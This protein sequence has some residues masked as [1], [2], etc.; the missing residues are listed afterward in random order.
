MKYALTGASNDTMYDLNIGTG[1]SLYVWDTK[2]SYSCV[3]LA[4]PCN[5]ASGGSLFRIYY[6]GNLV[7]NYYNNTINGVRPVVCIKSSVP[8]ELD[9]NGNFVI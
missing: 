7:R 1:D 8:A 6:A 4:S 5:Y 2:S 3:W 9:A